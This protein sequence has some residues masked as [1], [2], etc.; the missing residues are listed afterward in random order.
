[1][2]CKK[3]SIALL[4]SAAIAASLLGCG[5]GSESGTADTPP[6]T[7]TQYVRQANEVCQAGLHKKDQ[8]VKAAAERQGQEVLADPEAAQSLIEEAVIP[9]YG[10]TISQL[11]QLNPP[12][13][14]KGTVA[15]MI[16]DYDAALQE[17]KSDPVAAF[18]KNPF[19]KANEV[20]AD[21]GLTS[22]VF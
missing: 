12:A 19:A 20:A 2:T 14:D 15:K 5:G 6:L 21:Y 16:G 22:C 17:T 7:K 8:Q 3:S 1:M 9:T 11:K 18:Q 13:N 4:V 10:E